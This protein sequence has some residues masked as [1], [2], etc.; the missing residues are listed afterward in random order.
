MIRTFRQLIVLATAVVGTTLP[1]TVAAEAVSS[2]IGVVVMHGKGGA[3]TKHVAT[4]ASALESK[5]YLV[6]NLEMPWSGRRDYDVDVNH[7]EEEVE[8]ALTALRGKGAR[9]VFVAGHSQ[10]GLFALYLAGKHSVDGIIA[11]APGGSVGGAVYLEK[12]GDSVAQARKLIAEGKGSEKSRLSDYEGGK[13]TYP[14]VAAPA[15][16]LTWFDPDGAMNM[17]RA[18]R[19]ANP[20]IPILWIVAK[21]DYPNLRKVNIPLFRSLPS[22][23]LTKFYEPD[24]DHLGAPSASIDEIVR[25]TAEVAGKASSAL[26]GTPRAATASRQEQS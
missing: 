4:L 17:N 5:G 24:S 1:L 21:K 14:V 26:P 11:I 15:V 18:A 25:W 8:S 2:K 19:A 16:Y 20:R 3:P 12:L 10:G 22:N 9:R 23:P 6:A 13:G 7:A